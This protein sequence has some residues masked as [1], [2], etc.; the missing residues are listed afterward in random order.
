[1]RMRE[2]ERERERE[3]V[4]MCLCVTLSIFEC[5]LLF[6]VFFRPVLFRINKNSLVCLFWPI[7]FE[8]TFK[9]TQCLSKQFPNCYKQVT[10]FWVE[11]FIQY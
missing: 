1:M 8:D 5:Y 9:K 2:R 6:F 4:C 3:N 11:Q 10:R 7:H